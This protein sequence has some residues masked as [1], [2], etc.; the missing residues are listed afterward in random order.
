[1]ETKFD[2]TET[3]SYLIKCVPVAELKESMYRLAL[4]YGMKVCEHDTEEVKDDLGSICCIIGL[5]DTIK[6]IP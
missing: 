6:Q 2:F 5:L 1:M 3:S 4:N